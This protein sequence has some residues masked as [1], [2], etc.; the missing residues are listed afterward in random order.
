MGLPAALSWARQ[1][2]FPARTG[3]WTRARGVVVVVHDTRSCRQE[4][5][6]LCAALCRAGDGL[7][8]AAIRDC[9]ATDRAR[10]SKLRRRDKMP[11]Y[12]I[13]YLG[14]KQVANPETRA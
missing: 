11:K 13:A 6:G 7:H 1:R 5:H 10:P 12:V 4:H 2:Y 14:G 9:R 8:A 3:L